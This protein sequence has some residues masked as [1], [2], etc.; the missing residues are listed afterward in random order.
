MLSA[1]TIQV[2]APPPPPE[3]ILVQTVGGSGP[4][5]QF[6]I[7][8]TL[9][10][11]AVVIGVV[12]FPLVRAFARRLEGKGGAGPDPMLM[13]RV[14][15]LEHRLAEAEENHSE[16]LALL[17]EL[18]ATIT[19]EVSLTQKRIDAGIEPTSAL[20]D[21]ESRLAE[22]KARLAKAEEALPPP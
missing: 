15:D 14:S 1:M 4:P 12:L 21:V 8:I 5:E 3:P 11:I 10:A 20:N 2:P 6:F 16:E 19:E 13:E 17:R 22:A 9:I 18:V 7:A